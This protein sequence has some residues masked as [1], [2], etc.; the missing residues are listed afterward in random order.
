MSDKH[1]ILVVDD[2]PDILAVTKLGLKGLKYDDRK[3]E[4]LTATTGAQ[5][6]ET[7]AADPSMAPWGEPF[8]ATS[9][10]KYASGR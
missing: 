2:E 5:A 7:M 6:V 3:V 8:S 4:L 10:R 1:K 9:E